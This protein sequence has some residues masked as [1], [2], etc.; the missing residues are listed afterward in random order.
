M[1][2]QNIQSFQST[3]NSNLGMFIVKI[4]FNA[5]STLLAI[6]TKLDWAELNW[7]LK[8]LHPS[9]KQFI[10]QRIFVWSVCVRVFL[11]HFYGR[12]SMV[13]IWCNFDRCLTKRWCYF[14]INLNIG[15]VWSAPNR[16]PFPLAFRIQKVCS[17]PI[18]CMC[19][20]GLFALWQ[21]IVQKVCKTFHKY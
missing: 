8:Q 15:Y 10:M 3:W 5:P 12:Q 7:F 18:W 6:P 13:L 20:C 9:W 4:P 14:K 1:R 2:I 19:A 11:L 16:I 17:M 21:A